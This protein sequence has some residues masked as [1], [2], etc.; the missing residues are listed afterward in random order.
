MRLVDAFIYLSKSIHQ[1]PLGIKPMT[2]VLLVP[3]SIV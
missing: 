1:H 3:C 2:L